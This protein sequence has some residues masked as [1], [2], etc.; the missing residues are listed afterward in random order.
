MLSGFPLVNE[1]TWGMEMEVS[2]VHR[3]WLIIFQP[4][5]TGAGYLFNLPDAVA[6]HKRG[7]QVW[8]NLELTA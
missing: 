3:S 5:A 8:Y 2:T 7:D 6:L 1:K 4:L